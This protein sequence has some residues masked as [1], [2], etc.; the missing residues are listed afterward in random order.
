MVGFG[1]M[2][3]FIMIT[4][5]TA[6][7][8]SLGVHM[9]LATMTAAAIGQVVS[10]VSGVVFGD[11]LSKVF[12]VAPA[13]LSSAQKTSK[14]T[15]SIVSRL[16]L[17]GA[18][19]G[20]VAGCTLGAVALW[21]IPDNGRESD[22]AK[23][24]STATTLAV[25]VPVSVPVPQERIVDQLDRLQKVMTDIM[26]SHD[27]K[28]HDRRASCTLY[29][30]ESVGRYIPSSAATTKPT[31]T[32]IFA[33]WSSD[34]QEQSAFIETLANNTDPEVIH[35][36]KE[37]RV[38]VFANTIYVPVHSSSNNENDNRND[39]LGIFKIKLENGSF[40]TGSEIKDAKR[41]ARNLGFFLNHIV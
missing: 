9:G 5:G 20:V 13:K 14:L 35:T 32:S 7:D 25:S 39:I 11:T 19:I 38:V 17:S 10:D 41:V 31:V 26:T 4:A 30:N 27:D 34:H 2:D 16:R 15:R 24:A 29:V 23:A 8:N 40:Y 36:L 28:W 21:L 37:G 12:K 3:N 1:F 18:V 22:S 6:I 33:D